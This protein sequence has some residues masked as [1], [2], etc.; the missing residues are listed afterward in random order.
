MNVLFTG[1]P[2]AGKSLL[3]HMTL[4]WLQKNV[5][6]P[7]A[8]VPEQASKL[9]AAGRDPHDVA[10]FQSELYRVQKKAED[11]A[12]A[13]IAGRN[14]LP[15][16]ILI[17]DRGLPDGGCYMS[18][19][20]FQAILDANGDTVE[21]LYRRYDLVLHLGSVCSLGAA[22]ETESNPYRYETSADEVMALEQKLTRSYGNHPGYHFIPAAED[23]NDKFKAL[24]ST[25][26]AYYSAAHAA[27]PDC[28][29]EA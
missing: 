18:E 17:M 19:E 15:G 9:I 4:E 24:M 25:L 13:A 5:S 3:A 16:G 22:V 20:G 27:A 8:L 1:A 10:A 6:I 23:I 26:L 28:Q 29:P 21:K 12:A 2:M 11:L 14:G 7:L